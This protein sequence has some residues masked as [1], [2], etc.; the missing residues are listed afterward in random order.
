VTSNSDFAFQRLAAELSGYYLL[1]FEA[2][3]N[4]RNSRPHTISVAVRRQGATVR[5]RHQ[6]TIGALPTSTPQSQIVATLRDPLPA[7]DIRVR[8]TTYSFR[9]P[10]SSK[11]RLM[12]A[13]DI[14]RSTNDEGQLA[15]GYV[16]VDF[17]GKLVAS[18][19]DALDAHAHREGRRQRYFST[20]LADAGKYTLKL[21]VVDETGRRGSVERVVHAA[22]AAAGPIRATDLMVAA[23]GSSEVKA[24]LAPTVAAEFT[25]STLHG[26]LE[27]FADAPDTLKEAAVRLEVAEA[28]TSAAVEQVDMV[29]QTVEND[30]RCRI[31]G[32][33]VSVKGLSPGSYLARAVI[34]VRGRTVGRVTRPFRIVRP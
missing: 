19:F 9:D 29:L 5:S 23:E 33:S 10:G 13:A 20:V 4:D 17:N 22:L 28:E 6:F 24:P 32:A 1:G 30:P 2:A 14:D 16:V 25:G 18:Q 34:T 15:V 21:A 26:Y 8:V 31:A 27:L 7:T 3:D 11:L 12:V